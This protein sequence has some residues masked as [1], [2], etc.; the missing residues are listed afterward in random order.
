MVEIL[1]ETVVDLFP[2]VGV[3]GDANELIETMTGT[4]V[5]SRQFEPKLQPLL[6]PHNLYSGF[7]NVRK[8]YER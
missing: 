8:V 7:L 2:L 5:N 1:I 3:L 6:I 4:A